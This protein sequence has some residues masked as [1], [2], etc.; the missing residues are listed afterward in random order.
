M[1]S[2]LWA[3]GSDSESDSDSSDSSDSA[4]A[5]AAAA[6]ATARGARRWAEASS[7]EEDEVE[8]KRTVRS[9]TDKKYDLVKSKIKVLVTHMKTTDFSTVTSDYE[10]M[11]RI[12]EKLKVPPQEDGTPDAP[13]MFV[14]A[15]CNL[16]TYVE[17]H[18]AAQKEAK[19]A[20]NKGALTESKARAFNTLRAKVR[21]GNK[22]F[23]TKINSYKEHPSEFESE[24]E[25][26][27]AKGSDN[28][29]S[30][31]AASSGSSSS[32]SSSSSGSSSGSG[33]D[34]DSDSDSN[35]GSGSDSD[36][37]SSG[38]NSGSEGEADADV[39]RERKMLR[40]LI[41]P[42]AKAKRDA[43]GKLDKDKIAEDKKEGKKPRPSKAGK[44]TGREVESSGRDKEPD[45]YDAEEL[46]KKVTE[47]AQSRG[48]RGFDRKTY[49]EKMMTMMLHAEKQGPRHVLYIYAS[50]VSAD[51]DNTGSVHN[52][53]N[54][55]LWNAALDKVNNM[56]PLLIASYKD[57]RDK[58][59]TF[60]QIEA[61]DDDENS[62]PTNHKR[63]QDLFIAVAEKLDDE[64]YKALQFISDVYG[65]E[66]QEILANSSK[67]LVLLK[68]MFHFF[69]D[70]QQ[71]QA[72]GAVSLRLMEQMYYKP[73][74]LNK[75]V[76][77]SIHHTAPEAEKPSWVWPEN[78]TGFMATLCKYVHATG[79]VHSQRRA[80]LCQ[81]FHL[82]L[83]DHFQKARDL[84]HLTNLEEKSRE[85]DINMQIL[86]NRCLAQMGLCA[87]RLGKVQDAHNCLMDV[88]MHG[89]NRELLAQGL[90]FS[91]FQDRT[92]EQER[93]ERLRQLPYHM[94]I[95]LEVLDSAHHLCAMLL[96]VPNLALQAID[97]TSKRGIIS[98]VLRR[99]LDHHDKQ[100]FVGPPENNKE[101]VVSAAKALQ[102][103]DWTSACEAV[104][105]LKLWD[106]IDVGNPSNGQKVKE[107][108]KEKMKTEAL[109][110][111][112]FA[113]MSI[114]DAFH[115]GQLVSMFDLPEKQVHSVVSK[116]MMK[117]EITAFWDESSK[118][119]LMQHVEPTPLQR[120]AL[121]L[122]DRAAQSVENNERLVDHKMGGYGFQ[123]QKGGGKGG[124]WEG[125]DRGKGR[126]GKGGAG[127]PTAFDGGKGK[128]KGRFGKSARPAQNRGWENARA[129]AISGRAQA[130]WGDRRQNDAAPKCLRGPGEVLAIGPFL[131][132][133]ALLLRAAALPSSASG[134]LR[135]GV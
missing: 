97:P 22:I 77:D 44:S 50:M 134:V 116:M 73:D 94:H 123:E 117:E 47:I 52:A 113:Y 107:M 93:A 13:A 99:A 81:V 62:D 125:G 41:T 27:L 121:S 3:G 75:A 66:Y 1:N 8:Q 103:G 17:E 31:S 67:F 118:Y 35:S 129:G 12:L 19:A 133:C 28:S 126:F 90:S 108:I 39:A 6:T 122:A 124:R 132:R 55:I 20:G 105:D 104:D 127:L 85:S 42:E 2:R 64:L 68:R 65:T 16:E 110:T 49:V 26:E 100:V 95:N 32:S 112:L 48:R 114:Y 18:F 109:R 57:L 25:E 43:K 34:S 80:L 61:L 59:M 128:G 84:L 14:K 71:E 51:F 40:W 120:L 11:I 45:E 38:S 98:K 83:H 23:E 10:E 130:G 88:C 33:S 79:N 78:S 46:V 5:A 24:S 7:D 53:M 92:P 36:T 96:E 89:K 72:L 82:A 86:Y 70:T 74:I 21:K 111:Y 101:A 69:E 115:L 29:D 54:M 76:Y 4:P 15:I 30:E 58:G 60:K 119:L 106:H 63:Q 135:W 87:F 102:K 56:L 37:Y 91:R 9:A 131:T